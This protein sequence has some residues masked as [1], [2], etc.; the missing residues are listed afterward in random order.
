MRPGFG[1]GLGGP[2][3]GAHCRGDLAIAQARRLCRSTQGVERIRRWGPILREAAR[4]PE[5]R[6]VPLALTAPRDP[7]REPLSIHRQLAATGTGTGRSDR[8]WIEK[9][10]QPASVHRPDRVRGHVGDPVSLHAA[11]DES[12]R[13][14]GDDVAAVSSE[15]DPRG[16]G[17]PRALLRTGRRWEVCVRTTGWG[18]HQQTRSTDEP[19]VSSAPPCEAAI[20]RA[21][22]VNVHHNDAR[23]GARWDADVRVRRARPPRGDQCGV[24]ARGEEPAAGQR[25]LPAG[26]AGE[27][28]HAGRGEATCRHRQ[29]R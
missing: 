11:L 28:G 27:D 24:A 26:E 16:G 20:G 18:T 7:R 22:N 13:R 21:V 17:L 8:T 2:V 19:R 1:D 15:I 12:L 6:P 23:C 25:T 10:P 5:Q 29:T 4:G 3:G 9:I 14:R